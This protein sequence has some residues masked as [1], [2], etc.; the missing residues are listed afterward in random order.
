VTLTGGTTGLLTVANIG[1]GASAL[2]ISGAG[3]W[4][5]NGTT[6]VTLTALGP[7]GANT[8]VQKWLTLTD[9]GGVV[10]YIPCF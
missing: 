5:A 7:A 9:N 6:A 4:T 1:N 3:Q 2:T 8:T 10:R